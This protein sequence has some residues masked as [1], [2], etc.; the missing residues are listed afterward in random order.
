MKKDNETGHRSDNVFWDL[1]KSMVHTY[2][3]KNDD[4]F[5]NELIDQVQNSNDYSVYSRQQSKEELSVLTPKAFDLLLF[6]VQNKE[7]EISFFERFMTILIS[8]I[9]KIREPISEDYIVSII[10]MIS[11]VDFQDHIIFTTIDLYLE[12]PDVLFR[13]QEIIH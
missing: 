13:Q 6:W 2:N 8:Y 9:G 11:I 5:P 7:I 1:F 3:I 12:A 10:E 4:F